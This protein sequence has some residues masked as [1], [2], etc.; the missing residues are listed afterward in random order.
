[1]AITVLSDEAYEGGFYPVTVTF[2]DEGGN[3]ETPNDNTIY[4]TL[5]DGDGT[6]IN[7]RDNELIASGASVTIAL[8]NDDLAIQ[9]GETAAVVKRHLVVKWE[10][11]SALGNNKKG[12]GEAIFP[13][14]N[15][16]RI[17]AAAA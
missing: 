8:E 5:T 17:P 16:T 13:L 6:V 10:Y 9:T 4:W 12:R 14:R 11:N 2:T 3:A 15:L 7:D 1:M